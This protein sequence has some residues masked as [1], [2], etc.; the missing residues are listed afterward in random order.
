MTLLLYDNMTRH[1]TEVRRHQGVRDCFVTTLGEGEGRGTGE[2]ETKG[3]DGLG[4]GFIYIC[5]Y[6]YKVILHF[7]ECNTIIF[8]VFYFTPECIYKEKIFFI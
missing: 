1:G 7:F 5:L 4:R 6:L 3:K 2:A 8:S